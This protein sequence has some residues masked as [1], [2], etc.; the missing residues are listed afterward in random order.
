[1]TGLVLKLAPQERV[2]I[3]GAVIENH[4]RRAKFGILTPG[5]HIL[6]LREAL[7]PNEVT[8]PLRQVCFS[9]QM[10]LSGDESF[11]SGYPKVLRGI[12]QLSLLCHDQGDRDMLRQAMEMALQG[13]MY[14]TLRCLR[15]L[16][17]REARLMTAMGG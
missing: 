12:D 6:R 11:E 15:Q 4:D 7:H 8:T 2:L 13:Q 3:N 1:M 16:L 5:V 14:Q 17:P 9:V 10:I